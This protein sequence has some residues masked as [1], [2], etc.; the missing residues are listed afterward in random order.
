M[1]HFVQLGGSVMD[2]MKLQSHTGVNQCMRLEGSK[3]GREG[4]EQARN[5]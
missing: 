3:G 1:S 5:D 2:G 4:R